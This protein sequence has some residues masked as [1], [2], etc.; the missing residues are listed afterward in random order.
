MPNWKV[1]GTIVLGTLVGFMLNPHAPLGAALFGAPPAG[2]HEPTGGQVGAL[3]A[4][5]L[6]EA[7]AFGLGLAFLV[8]G[9]A[10]MARRLGS[11]GSTRLAHLAVVW[12]LMSWVPHTAMHQTNGDNI[13]RLIVIEYAF[14]VT[15]VLAAAALAWAFVRSS[16]R[17]AGDLDAATA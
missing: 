14:H 16:G 3:M 5:A 9:Y 13:A 15:L 7:I 6:V 12:G 2:D 10:A 1:I 8:F 4:V 11:D 17:R